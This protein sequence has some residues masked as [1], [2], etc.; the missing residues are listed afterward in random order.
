MHMLL[1]SVV[2]LWVH[3]FE[4]SYSFTTVRI[5]SVI[6]IFRSSRMWVSIS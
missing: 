6:F 2:V 5:L 4:D 3:L 1:S